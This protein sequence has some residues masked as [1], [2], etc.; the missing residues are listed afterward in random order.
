MLTISRLA[1]S[2][3]RTRALTPLKCVPFAHTHGC[4]VQASVRARCCCCSHRTPYKSTNVGGVYSFR[5]CSFTPVRTHACT[6]ARIA[7]TPRTHTCIRQ[8]RF[9]SPQSRTV[10]L[11]PVS[12]YLSLI[13]HRSIHF[14]YTC[15]TKCIPFR[16]HRRNRTRAST[17]R[18][19]IRTIRSPRPRMQPTAA[20]AAP[21]ATTTTTPTATTV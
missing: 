15:T 16:R 13:S 5:P 14:T 10:P 17:G 7:F 3:S 11:S 21:A 4:V 12:Q 8:P 9:R 20:A 6:R 18:G 19:S 2:F 1:H